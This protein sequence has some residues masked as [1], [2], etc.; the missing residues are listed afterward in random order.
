[1]SRLLLLNIFIIA[2]FIILKVAEGTASCDDIE[3]AGPAYECK[4]C[5]ECDLE[6]NRAYGTCRS[7][8]GP[9]GCGCSDGYCIGTDGNCVLAEN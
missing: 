7:N 9:P 4:S 2:S 5:P 1:M 6:C 3:C 8:C